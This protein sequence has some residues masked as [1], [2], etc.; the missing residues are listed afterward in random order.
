MTR[1][2]RH[3]QKATTKCF[4][5]HYTSASLS[6][7]PLQQASPV[8]TTTTRIPN[9]GH[10]CQHHTTTLN[11]LAYQGT[12]EVRIIVILATLERETLARMASINQHGYGDDDTSASNLMVRKN[13]ARVSSIEKKGKKKKRE[14]W[15]DER[16]ETERRIY[17]L[18]T[19]I[20][21][22]WYYVTDWNGKE[23]RECNGATDST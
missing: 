1:K 16:N 21:V 6:L 10:R 17:L 3:A 4:S 9:K 2:T 12:Y 15:I 5:S 13:K 19:I 7:Q 8:T 20:A 11:H 18:Y 23:V 22:L 14:K